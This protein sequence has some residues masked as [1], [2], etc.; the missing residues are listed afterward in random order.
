[1]VGIARAVRAMDRVVAVDASM[2]Q[3]RERLVEVASLLADLALELASYADHIEAD[4]RRQAWVEERRRDLAGLRRKYGSTV[5]EVLAWLQDAQAAVGEISGDDE[6]IDELGLQVQ[7]LQEQLQ[8]A[9]RVLTGY[10][11]DAARRLAIEVTEELSALAMPEAVFTVQVHT[12]DDPRE[13]TPHGADEIAF[14]LEPH[15]GAGSRPL[16]KGASGGELSRVMLAIEVALAGAD[17]VPT[18]VFDEV[19][20]GVGGRAAVEVGRRLARLGRTSQVLV[21]THLPQVAAFA[22][23]HVVVTKDAGGMVT[24]STVRAVTGDDRV[25]ELVRMLSGLD[26]SDAGLA[27]AEELLAAAAADRSRT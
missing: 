18:F 25:A 19:D 21:V 7:V 22:D 3:P 1:M 9:A 17:P 27:H 23:H 16:G 11:L 6:R 8:Q 15:P 2:G 26:A 12:R 24:A 5:D 14:L 20:A 10:R 13:F 4:P